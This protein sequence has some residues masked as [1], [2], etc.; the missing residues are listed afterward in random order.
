PLLPSFITGIFFVMSFTRTISSKKEKTVWRWNTECG[1]YWMLVE[2]STRPNTTWG[3]YIT[4]NRRFAVS[5]VLLIH[6]ISSIP[7]SDGSPGI[8][9]GSNALFQQSNMEL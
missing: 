6:A 3:T 5:T 7:V 2:L 1:N 4:R 9:I 8:S